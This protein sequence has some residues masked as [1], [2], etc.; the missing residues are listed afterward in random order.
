[1]RGYF[2]RAFLGINGLGK[3]GK[4]TNKKTAL[5]DDNLSAAD[6]LK[7]AGLSKKDYER[8]DIQI[9]MVHNQ[10]SQYWDRKKRV[11]KLFKQ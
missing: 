11:Q 9:S 8:W 10:I 6:C 3:N 7:S 1:M 4:D 5:L 2:T